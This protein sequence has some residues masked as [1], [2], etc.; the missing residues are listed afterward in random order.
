MLTEHFSCMTVCGADTSEERRAI[1]QELFGIP[2]YPDADTAFALE[3]PDA[4]LICTPPTSHAELILNCLRNGMHVF[5]EINLMS[6]RY[7]EI[8]YTAKQNGLV[9][10]LS[11]TL[12]YRKEIQ[13]IENQVSK[14]KGKVN[15]RYHV[16][17]YL[18]DW[19]PWEDYREFFAAQKRTNA[20]REILAIELPWMI[21]VFG[22]ITG[23]TCVKDTITTLDIDFPDNYLI[24][25]QHENGNKGILIVD[26]VSRKAECNLL[27]YSENMHLM[28]DGTPN[29]LLQ[30][31]TADKTTEKIHTYPKAEHDDR[32]VKSIVE[33]AYVDEFAAF[34]AKI[35][36]DSSLERYTFAKDAETL[37]LIDRIEGDGA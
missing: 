13:F 8:Q 10:F 6:D 31:H 33:N 18:P 5:S 2:V 34:L 4:A 29:S 9:L 32:F 37:K 27:A 30:Y 23:V 20:C 12:L 22:K 11:S 25:L 3:K 19:H 15:Y 1:T 35:K 36:G 24:L 17:Q 28:W 14:Q 7:E 26:I 21:R 16:G